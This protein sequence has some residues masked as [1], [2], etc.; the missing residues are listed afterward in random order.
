MMHT[1]PIAFLVVVLA[2]VFQSPVR[3]AAQAPVDID[4]RIEKLVASVSQERL[5]QLLQKLS[6][7]KTRNTLSDP[8]APNG[9]GEARQ[10][11]LDELK[12]TSPRLQVSFDTHIIPA[13][14]R[15]PKDT[16][17]RNVL[18]I[19]PGKSPRRIYV[20]GHYDSLNLG[21]RGQD[22]LNTGAGR[23]GGRG[24]AEATQAAQTGQTGAAGQAGGAGARGGAPDQ[25]G[26]GQGAGRGQANDDGSGTVLSM[27][28]ARVFAESGIDFEATLVFMTVAGEEQGLLGAGAHA[29]KAK[30]EK[31]PVQALF[32]N[33]IVGNSTGGD[34]I[35]DGATVRV[36]SEGPED[37]L[38][39][40]LA[41]FTRRIG[42]RYVPSHRVR[43]IARRDRFSRGGDHSAFNAS[44]FAA[45]GFRESRENYSKQHNANDTI[46]GVSFPYLAQNARVNAAAM[47]TLA[48]APPPPVVTTERGAPT[49]DRRPSGYDA[50]LR[51][52]ASPG[53]AGYRIFWRDAWAPDW[54]H[55]MSVGNV[56]EY[57][58]P[59]K[60]IDDYV[61]GVA[62]VSAGGHESTISAY[63]SAPRSDTG[64]Q[65]AP[66]ALRSA[67]GRPEPGR[68]AAAASERS[69]SRRRE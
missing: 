46:D 16:E 30:E 26:R 68:G 21:P 62:A 37:S 13:R 60:N 64:S 6:S 51:W 45:I 18:A 20:S 34:G 42:E 22:S 36:Y 11:I 41:Q 53:A 23:E 4:P 12:R 33:D 40:L 29:K 58:L 35:V 19:L 39:R 27:E 17:L 5:Q 2:S 9:L 28:L 69:E 43:L 31:I 54:Q 52:T 38:S 55:E 32:N 67:Q 8:D 57:V 47:A 7:F 61:F 25:T 48:L 24:G 65:E 66:A 10:W 3:L 59:H 44:G 63:V 15:V 49:I 50:R 14:G 56:T 1:R